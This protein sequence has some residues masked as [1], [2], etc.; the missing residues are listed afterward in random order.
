MEIE[1]KPL[2][3]R[4]YDGDRAR[5]VL[6]NAAFQQVFADVERDLIESWKNIPSTNGPLDDHV[7][8]RERIHLSLTL[9]G[10]VKACLESSMETGTLA[11]LELEHKN[12]VQQMAQ[13]AKQ[14]VGAI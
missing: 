7:K 11:K 10:K 6:E 12:K 13:R 14:W 2:E 5:E 9:L 3:S 4:I 1:P 8:A